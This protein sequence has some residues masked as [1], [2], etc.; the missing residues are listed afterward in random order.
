[1]ISDANTL[2]RDM[3]SSRGRLDRTLERLTPIGVIEEVLGTVRRDAAGAGLYDGALEAVRR[4]P[5]TVLMM[6]LGAVTLT[7]IRSQADF[8]VVYR[9]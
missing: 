3:E 6:C 2:E 5:V 1:M 7:G 4:N 9:R 8:P